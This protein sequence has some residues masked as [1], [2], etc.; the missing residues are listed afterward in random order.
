[1]KDNKMTIGIFFPKN[2]EALFNKDCKDTFGGAS[3]QMYALAKELNRFTNI[4]TLSIIPYYSKI[5]FDDNEKFNFVQLYEPTYGSLKKLIRFLSFIKKYKPNFIIQHGL[6][7]ESCYLA[8]VCKIL[9]IKMIFMFA[10]D[11]EVEG[12]CQTYRTPIRPFKKLLKNAY[13]LITQNKYQHRY[14]VDEYQKLSHIYYNGFEMKNFQKKT[15]LKK[16]VLWVAR[17]DYWKRPEL[18]VQLAELNPKLNFTMICPLSTDKGLYNKI[19]RDASKQKNLTFLSF[20]PLN[21]I[22][23]YFEEASVFVNTS[24][25]EGF[26]QTFLQATIN[27]N[28]ILSLNV[29]PE[30]FIQQ[31]NCGYCCN[32]NLDI[33]NEKLREIF[34]K[35]SLFMELSQNAYRYAK[36]NHDI[37]INV[38]KILKK[39]NIKGL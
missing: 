28:I 5:N 6:T 12:L 36:E 14:L 27:A 15:V 24:D 8:F 18:F 9:R 23:K 31:Y 37:Q 26:P 38:N 20:V 7:V 3:V 4:S 19:K 35:K 11:C 16:N 1:M 17:C 34:A 39:L 2:S 30:N 21:K 10:H 33:M 22:T 29:D 13:L 32:G 25:S